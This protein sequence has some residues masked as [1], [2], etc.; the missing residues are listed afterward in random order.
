MIDNSEVSCV[1]VLEYKKVC[2]SDLPSFLAKSP[3]GNSLL[4]M[5]LMD[6]KVEETGKLAN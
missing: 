5:T 6:I 2:W 1:A 4:Q 3:T